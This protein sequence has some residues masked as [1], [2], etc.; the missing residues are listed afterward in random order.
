M[1]SVKKKY[2]FLIYLYSLVAHIALVFAVGSFA[3]G[4]KNSMNSDET[5]DL[6]K[7]SLAPLAFKVSLIGRRGNSYDDSKID[8]AVRYDEI[9]K[10]ISRNL[11]RLVEKIIEPPPAL[12][13]VNNS[14][15]AAITPVKNP[16]FVEKL[17]KVVE[18]K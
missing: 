6:L 13:S 12:E 2:I 10:L 14:A 9:K 1:I 17:E 4:V 3:A 15:V 18:K 8:T 7:E 11:P 16:A 5:A